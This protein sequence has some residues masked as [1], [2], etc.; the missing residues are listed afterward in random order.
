MCP[1]LRATP[2]ILNQVIVSIVGVKILNGAALSYGKSLQLK[3]YTDF[4]LS[5]LVLNTQ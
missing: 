2:F 5:Q 1:V 3:D 4:L